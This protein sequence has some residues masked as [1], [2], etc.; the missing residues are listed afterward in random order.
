MMPEGMLEDRMRQCVDNEWEV[1][2]FVI[3]F[4][5]EGILLNSQQNVQV[6]GL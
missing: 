3:D 2:T 1:I 6:R 5:V 4:R